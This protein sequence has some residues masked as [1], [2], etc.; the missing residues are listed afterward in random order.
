MAIYVK[1][2]ILYNNFDTRESSIL[3]LLKNIT[4]C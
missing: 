4:T 2:S 3:K 1:S